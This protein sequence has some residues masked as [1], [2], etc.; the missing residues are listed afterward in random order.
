[1]DKKTIISIILILIFIGFALRY[2]SLYFDSFSLKNFDC[3]PDWEEPEY[4]KDGIADSRVEETA[5]YGGDYLVFNQYSNGK[6]RYLYD[7]EEDEYDDSE[8]N[9]VR[10]AGT[11]YALLDLYK[12]TKDDRYMVAGTAGL[13]YLISF[14]YMIDWDK[15]AVDWGGK[16]KV[17]TVALAILG[18]VRYWEASDNDKY[19]IYVEKFANYIVSQQ[20]DDGAFAGIYGQKKESRY[21]SGE[22]FFALALAYDMLDKKAYREAMEDALDYYWSEDYDYSDAAFIPWASS[23]CAKWYELTENSEFKDFSFNMTDTQVARQSLV[24]ELDKYGNDLYGNILDPTVNTG[25]YLEGIGDVY[26]LAKSLYDSERTA[27][28][29]TSLKAGI[30]WVLTV[31]FRKKSQLACP[32]RGFGGFHRGFDVSDAYDVRID[33]VQHAIS[34]ILRVLREFSDWEIE[35]IQIHEGNVHFDPEA[36]DQPFDL[37]HVLPLTVV[38]VIIPLIWIYY[39]MRKNLFTK[40]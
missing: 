31:Q 7:A 13:D 27:K 9:I 23:G 18:M 6:F 30:E 10:H 38:L 16:M 40:E 5:R 11:C 17:G 25:V 4:Y 8:Y 15:W 33:Y 22:A 2:L 29:Y 28:Y 37:W 19:N 39:Y 34:A 20:R 3:D 36:S 21:Y 26:R 24:H 32:N 35:S 12:E 1:M 14:T